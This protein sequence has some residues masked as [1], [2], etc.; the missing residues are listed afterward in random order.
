VPGH[1]CHTKTNPYKDKN[2]T[3]KAEDPNKPTTS[4]SQGKVLGANY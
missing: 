4:K 2:T 1:H 3:V